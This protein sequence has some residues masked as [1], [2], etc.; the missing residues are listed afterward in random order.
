MRFSLLKPLGFILL[1]TS[2]L[3]WAQSVM[4]V[5]VIQSEPLGFFDESGNRAGIHYDAIKIIAEKSGIEMDIKVM[6]KNRIF[7]EIKDGTIDAAI[8]FPNKKWE[9]FTENGGIIDDTKVIA[10]GR[11]GYEIKTY[12]DLYTSNS[13]GLMPKMN[14]SPQ[15]DNDQKLKKEIVS[16]YET[17]IKML[18]NNR[19]DVAVGNI[20]VL[21]YQAKKQKITDKI[22]FPGYVLQINDNQFHI[23]KK[24]PFAGKAAQLRTLVAQIREENGFD[25]AFTKYLGESWG[26]AK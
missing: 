19:L 1:C 16:D 15:F 12:E 3:L 11:K 5:R 25:I 13:I 4:K 8:F 17:M 20:A 2:S 6:P 18:I 9:A 21:H 14:I 10:V 7:A 24:S 23:S 22:E 26:A